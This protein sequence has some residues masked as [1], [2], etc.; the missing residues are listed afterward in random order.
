MTEIG[1]SIAISLS[2]DGNDNITAHKCDWKYCEKN[3]IKKVTYPQGG[4]VDRNSTYEADWVAAGLEPWRLRGPGN[5]SHSS[6]AEYRAETPAAKYAITAAALQYP[7]Y[8]TQKHHLL[9]VNFFDTVKQLSHNAK[10]VGYNVNHKNNGICLPSYTIDIV[11][12]DLQ[13]HR[14]SHPK[15]LYNDK[16]KAILK[17]LE[18]KCVKYCTTATDGS[19]D[20]QL[21]L[22]DRLNDLSRHV[23]IKI[24]TWQWLLR[25]NAKQERADS[26]KRYQNLGR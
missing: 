16:V 12:H 24:L 6:L 8:H 1:E 17:N 19:N 26:R 4:S 15:V 23:E 20:R 13:C 14:G 11:Q 10:L 9:S 3:H 2:F 7:A 22:M 5:N 21:Q 18:K 25:S